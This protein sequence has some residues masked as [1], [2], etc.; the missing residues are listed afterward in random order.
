MTRLLEIGL[1]PNIVREIAGHS[2]LDAHASLE[3]KYRALSRLD[4][5]LSHA[6]L[7]ADRRQS[8]LGDGGEAV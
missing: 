6:L 3:E 2:A 4:D 1:P 7:A 8:G 5:R